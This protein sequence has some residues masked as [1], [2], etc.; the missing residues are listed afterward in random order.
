MGF[1]LYAVSMAAM[2]VEKVEDV[3]EFEV[4]HSVALIQTQT[5]WEAEMMGVMKISQ[6]CPPEGGWIDHTCNVLVASEDARDGRW[7]VDVIEKNTPP[8]GFDSR[9]ADLNGSVSVD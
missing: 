9:P 1:K 8:G 6:R 4:A 2:R 5:V 7:Q 3:Y